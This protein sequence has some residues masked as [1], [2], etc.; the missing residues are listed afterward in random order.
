VRHDGGLSALNLCRPFFERSDRAR[1]GVT[2]HAIDASATS[3]KFAP[4]PFSRAPVPAE[5]AAVQT[6]VQAHRSDLG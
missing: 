1:H 6:L 2:R 4:L 5:A 3:I